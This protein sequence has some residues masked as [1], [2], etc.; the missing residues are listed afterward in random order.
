MSTPYQSFNKF[1][2]Y[3]PSNSVVELKAVNIDI[4]LTPMS[5]IACHNINDKSFSE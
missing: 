1:G 3:E 4:F 2:K 5:V